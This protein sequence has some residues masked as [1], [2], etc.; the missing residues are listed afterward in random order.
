MEAESSFNEGVFDHLASGARGAV[1]VHVKSRSGRPGRA[2]EA[3]GRQGFKENAPGAWSV[4]DVCDWVESVGFGQYRKK[5]AHHAVDGPL[6]LNIDEVA[7]KREVGIVVYGH[8][9]RLA[10]EIEGLRAQGPGSPGTGIAASGATRKDAVRGGA[11]G[12]LSMEEYRV[13][14]ARDLSRAA[15]KASHN[16]TVAE[17]A[18]RQAQLSELELERLRT[19]LSKLDAE[20][21]LMQQRRPRDAADERPWHVTGEFASLLGAGKGGDGRWTEETFQPKLSKKSLEIMGA[22]GEVFLERCAQDL[23]NRASRLQELQNQGLKHVMGE[24]SNPDAEA[25]KFHREVQFLAGVFHEKTGVLLTGRGRDGLDVE[26]MSEAVSNHQSALGLS[27]SEVAAIKSAPAGKK[28]ATAAAIFHSK[29]FLERYSASQKTRAIK[30]KQMVESVLGAEPSTKVREAKVHA[31]RRKTVHHF[32]G[33]GWPLESLTDARLDSLL[34]EADTLREG[35]QGTE[36]SADIDGAGAKKSPM[37]PPRCAPRS[38]VGR[39]E[40]DTSRLHEETVYYLSKARAD[41]AW[42]KIK[43]T[44]GKQDGVPKKAIAI[45]REYLTQRFL[46]ATQED[47]RKREVKLDGRGGAVGERTKPESPGAGQDG[48]PGPKGGPGGGVITSATGTASPR[49]PHTAQPRGASSPRGASP[50]PMPPQEKGVGLGFTSDRA[51]SLG[52]R[53]PARPGSASEATSR[54]PSPPKKRP[55]GGLPS[56]RRTFGQSL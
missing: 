21:K 47:L 55:A 12:R 1:A 46:E 23:R 37:P 44:K 28:H 49:R 3:A 15:A 48:T 20:I 7:L 4:R 5:F 9:C 42:E 54:E 26:A 22:S 45:Y 11:L 40:G 34:R 6:L 16:R 18:E 27:D 2:R 24:S 25:K 53:R 19:Q 56:P 41:G 32:R 30:K 31:V 13:R 50:R 52:V 8:R 36:E 17:E 35:E 51:G 10:E 38:P 33:L 43:Q 29:Q 39:G 14:L